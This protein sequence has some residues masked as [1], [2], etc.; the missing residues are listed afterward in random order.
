MTARTLALPSGSLLLDRVRIMGILNRTPDSFY[1]H[2]RYLDLGPAL[3]RA[4]AMMAEGVDIIDVGGEKAGPGEPVSVEEETR[5]VVPVIEELR[6]RCAVPISVDTFK[7][8]V[9]RRAIGAGADI[10]NSIGGFR[11]P[12]MRHVAAD[13]GAAAI[14]M[15]IRREP[16]VADPRPAYRDVVVEVRAFLLER[17][18]QCIA[19]GVRPESIVIDPGPGFGKTSE[20]DVDI[21]RHVDTFTALPFP[22]LLAA[23]R[24]RFIGDVLGLDVDDR[25]EGSLAVATWGALRGVKIIRTHDVEATRRVV[26]MTEA[27]LD[28][29]FVPEFGG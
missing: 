23:S 11:D 15:H 24:K 14:I 13:T 5:R 20:H 21:L 18:R 19:D 26:R 1:D 29:D 9:A 6:R 8:E 2:G 22:V 25:L 27:V 28:P 16:R 3:Q 4:D 7:P 17:A 10:I 12:D